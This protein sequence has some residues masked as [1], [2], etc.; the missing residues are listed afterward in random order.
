MAEEQSKSDHPERQPGLQVTGIS[1]I[2][3]LTRMEKFAAFWARL[4]E[5]LGLPTI[6]IGV[7]TWLSYVGVTALHVNYIKPYFAQERVQD[8]EKHEQELTRMKAQEIQVEEQTAFLRKLQPHV[9]GS[10]RR[11]QEKA[12]LDRIKDWRQLRANE[13][14]ARSLAKLAGVRDTI[15]ES[16][17]PPADMAADEKPEE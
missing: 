1:E 5:R 3:P 13:Q 7:I 15:D 4:I 9:E 17:E 6:L 16:V 8:Q 2:D 14:V 11:A 12:Q 10:E